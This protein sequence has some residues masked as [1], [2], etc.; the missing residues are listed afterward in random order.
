MKRPWCL[1]VDFPSC[2]A[3]CLKAAGYAG[4]IA[5]AVH[6]QQL[7]HHGV[8]RD[9]SMGLHDDDILDERQATDSSSLLHHNR[10]F[11][12]LSLSGAQSENACTAAASHRGQEQQPIPSPFASQRAQH[13][14]PGADQHWGPL[15]AQL[16]KGLSMSR[17][18]T[19]KEEKSLPFVCAC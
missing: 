10:S 8:C 17:M 11:A 5:L 15:T 14:I 2:V 1:P 6:K 19:L 4:H 9:C 16:S 3:A 18:D 12:R 13:A 7:R